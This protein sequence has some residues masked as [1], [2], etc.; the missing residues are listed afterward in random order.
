MVA[1]AST[2]GCV[3]LTMKKHP[4]RVS[5]RVPLAEI[6]EVLPQHTRAAVA[7]AGPDG[8]ECVPVVTRR[9]ADLLIGLNR[10]A[11]STAALPDRVV[12]VVDA[13][14]YWFELRAAVWRGTV[15]LADEGST[16]ASGD[17][18]LVWLRLHPRRVVAW[19]YGRLHE[20]SAG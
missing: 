7:F 16:D 13:G 4:G 10:C 6:A 15:K 1:P 8:P 12:L 2:E 14:H 19:D 20:E 11:L 18:G 9:D 17:D 3:R 5:Q